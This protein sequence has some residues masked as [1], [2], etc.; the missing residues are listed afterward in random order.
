MKLP[1]EFATR[2]CSEIV[3]NV[4][5][6][7]VLEVAPRLPPRLP[8]RFGSKVDFKVTSD[9]APPVCFASLPRQVVPKVAPEF[10]PKFSF[11]CCLQVIPDVTMY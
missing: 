8:L 1:L 3:P 2:R 10:S 5:S 6:K 4:V 11:R 9:G 7:I